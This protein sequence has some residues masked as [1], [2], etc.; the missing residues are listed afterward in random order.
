MPASMKA[1]MDRTLP[2]SN[3]A[4]QKVGDRYEH[5]GQADYS[6]LKYLMICG[7]GFPNSRKNIEPAIMQFKLC[8]P[9]NHT[10]ITMPESPM[11]NAPE[12]VVV[13]ASR[14]EL[15]KQAGQQYAEKCAIEA[16]LLSEIT[17]PMIPEDQYAAIVNSDV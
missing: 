15:I 9:C 14:L 13:T 12:A 10:I 4:M 16:S 7:C 8:F 6:R 11:F 5:V 3:M 1:L 17:S 2:L